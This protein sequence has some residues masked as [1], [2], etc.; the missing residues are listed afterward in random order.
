MR[1]HAA[2][3][4]EL[5]LFEDVKGG[6]LRYV[7]EMTCA[8][9][10]LID[11]AADVNGAPRRAIAFRLVPVSGLDDAGNNEPSA[12][13]SED[14]LWSQSLDDLL[15]AA[16]DASAP[17]ESKEARRRV[18]IRSRALRTYVLQRS[19]G[20]CEGCQAPAPF[21]TTYGHP[22]LDAHHT[23]RISDGGPDDPRW[24]IALCP[25]CHR[26]SH[27]ADDHEQFNESLKARL[28]SSEH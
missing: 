26:R 6:F 1:D 23:R 3:G 14:R 9:Y 2:E 24:V 18:W 17:G 12:D 8:G 21:K 7:D 5:H 11:G 27:H 25:N 16:E 13:L 10:T 22:Y 4:R 15:K 20:I 19:K 28:Q